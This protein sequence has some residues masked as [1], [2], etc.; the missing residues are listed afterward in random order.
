VSTPLRWD[1]VM[2]CDPA[3][4]TV[5]TMPDR[6]AKIGD[7]HAAMD[8][9]PGLLD[10]LLE[11]AARDQ[12][13]G[14]PDAPWPPHFRKMEGEPTRAQPSKSR[15]SSEKKKKVTTAEGEEVD[16][17]AAAVVKKGRRQS[18]MPLIVVAQSSDKSAAEAGLERWKE[19]HPQAAALLVPDDVLVD[20]M[21]GSAYVWYRIRVNLRHVPEA[22]RPAQGVPDPDDDPTRAWRDSK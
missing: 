19:Q 4:F 5:L 3:D 22:S 2:L 14:I 11:M 10:A 12:A 20:R 8:E 15:A 9:H 1:E 13:Q 16:P 17:A 18:T 6:F 21:R 7:P